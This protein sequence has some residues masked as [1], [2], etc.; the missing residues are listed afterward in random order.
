MME[1]FK[2]SHPGAFIKRTYLEPFDLKPSVV[3]NK[4]NVSPSTF[5]RLIYEKSNVSPVLALKLSKVLGRTPESWL[6][7]Q[8]NFD[9]W[10]ARL[11]VDL[12]RCERIRF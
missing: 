9:L 4:L 8:R 5:N 6:T 12:S 11:I 1:P 10:Q 7:M 2:P 3:A